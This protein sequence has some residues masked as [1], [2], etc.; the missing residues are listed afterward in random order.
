MRLEMHQKHITAMLKGGGVQVSKLQA[1][2]AAVA[3][4]PGGP[5]PGGP[6]PGDQNQN[7]G[8]PTGDP[9]QQPPA[10]GQHLH[11]HMHDARG[12]ELAG[13]GFPPAFPAG[14]VASGS[15]QQAFTHVDAAEF[16]AS[17]WPEDHYPL[18]NGGAHMAHQQTELEWDLLNGGS[19]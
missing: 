8:A 7:P 14:G 5:N 13:Q 10:A 3:Q 17:I 6:N 9:Q 15:E 2:L 4:D 12:A 11:M 18:D 19:G 16:A 1:S